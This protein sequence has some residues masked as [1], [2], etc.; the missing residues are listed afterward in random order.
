MQLSHMTSNEVDLIEHL[1]RAKYL[2]R[3][4]TTTKLKNAVT[5][6]NNI[7]SRWPASD[8]EAWNNLDSVEKTKWVIISEQWLLDLKVYKPEQYEILVNNW[9]NIDNENV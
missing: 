1:A 3:V 6:F 7:D 5:L 2:M 4:F 9:K 8:Y